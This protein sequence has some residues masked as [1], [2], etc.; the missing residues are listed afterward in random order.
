MNTN[1]EKKLIDAIEK[2]KKAI[3]LDSAEKGAMRSEIIAFMK[4]NPLPLE[5]K[6]RLSIQWLSFS[7]FNHY[8]LQYATLLGA[9]VLLVGCGG[10]S[11]A[12]QSSLPGDMLYSMKVGVNEKVLS[13][14]KFSDKSKAQ[15]DIKLAQVRL[16]EIEKVSLEKKLDSKTNESLTSSLNQHITD[17]RE[18]SARIQAGSNVSASAQISSDLE[19]SLNAH[20]KIISELSQKENNYDTENLK[21]V[22]SDLEGKNTAAK[23]AREE[24]ESR[25][26]A[27]S[28]AKVEASAEEALS[29]ATS[30]ITAVKSFLEKSKNKISEDFY[31]V[32]RVDMDRASAKVVEGKTQLNTNDYGG[33][34]STFQHAIRIAQETKIGI[35]AV[36]RLKVKPPHI[37]KQSDDENRITDSKSDDNYSNKGNAK[38]KGLLKKL[39]EIHN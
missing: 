30:E 23:T 3:S 37:N 35:E 8:P 5:H 24:S 12:A 11:F 22:L 28:V 26:S 34:F 36:I 33:A 32:L 1:G 4:K 10:I 31:S 29:S 13:F 16:E 17:A 20:T 15:Y 25:L 2:A 7:S 38:P 39:L 21:N 27:K 9:F 14:L 18:R 19:A 6:K